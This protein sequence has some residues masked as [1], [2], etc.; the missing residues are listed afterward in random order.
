M[1]PSNTFISEIDGLPAA[2]PI[3]VHFHL[4]CNIGPYIDRARLR[5]MITAPNHR[6]LAK[7]ILAEILSSCS[8][9]TQVAPRLFALDGEVLI[10]TAASKNFTVKVP[11]SNNLKDAEFGQFLKA[12]CEACEACPD[13]ITL[14]PGPEKCD[15]CC[16]Q[17]QKAKEETKQDTPA[18]KSEKEEQKTRESQNQM[19]TSQPSLGL[20]EKK[21]AYKRRRQSD[22]DME[23][24]SPSPTSSSSSSS[25]SSEQ[26]VKM[27]R[28]SVETP[29]TSI[30]SR[31]SQV[32]AITTTSAT[33]R[34]KGLIKSVH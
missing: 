5:S 4:K 29:D 10:V 24:S 2:M 21:H 1:K 18:L 17:E 3:T 28:K 34:C 15:N 8:D 6:T 33:G 16:K 20:P 9:T 7:S 14:E 27:P 30:A 13:L 32:Q 11:N 22:I 19:D 25:S 31:K 26:F 23:S 12:I